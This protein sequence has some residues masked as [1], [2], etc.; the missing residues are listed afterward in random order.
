MKNSK[1]LPLV[2]LIGILGVVLFSAK[3]VMVK[4][5]YQYNVSA[6]N[7]L[8]FRM[9]FALPFYIAVLLFTKKESEKLPRK[10]YVWLIVFGF[11][12]YYLASYFDI[13]GKNEGYDLNYR[14]VHTGQHYDKKLSAT[15]FDELSI[16]DPNVNLNVGSG[17]QAEQTAAIMI[18]FE[19]ELQTFPT[20]LVIVVGDVTSTMACSIVAKK[21]HIKVL[22]PSFIIN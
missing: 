21:L 19:K 13:H 6:V 14:L 12:G 11:I 20:D 4:L 5:A 7:L 10:N 17:T 2:I 18:G 8:M 3:A 9:L 1:K 22:E 15:F 16:P